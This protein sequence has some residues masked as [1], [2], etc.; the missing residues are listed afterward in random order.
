MEALKRDNTSSHPPLTT[1][2]RYKVLYEWN[3]NH[4][5]YDRK[6]TVHDLFAAQARRTPERSAL[7]YEGT[8]LTY[9]ELEQRANQLAQHLITLGVGVESL[10]AL[11]VPRSLEMVIGI[12]GIIKAGGAYVPVDPALPPARIKLM[13]ED[14]QPAVLLTFAELLSPLTDAYT[15]V[16]LDRDWPLIAQQPVEM[17]PVKMSSENLAYVIY[18]S[19]STGTPKGVMVVHRAVVLLLEVYNQFYTNRGT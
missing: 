1:A 9:A 16:C 18:T 11:Y 15:A 13:L 8:T 7:T 3:A 5:D 19:G 12:L 17:Q 2:E 14:A 4:L 6:S 10:V